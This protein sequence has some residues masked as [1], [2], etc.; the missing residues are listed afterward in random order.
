MGSNVFIIA[1]RTRGEF[2]PLESMR[3]I[4]ENVRERIARFM[5]EKWNRTLP[6]DEMMADR[7]KKARILGLGEGT[8]VYENSYIYGKPK[9]GKDVWIG[10]LT[11]LDAT[12]GLQIGNNCSIAAGVHIYTHAVQDWVASEG[13]IPKSKSP[14]KIEDYV[15]VG[16]NAVVLPGV[17]IGH[18]SIIGAGSVVTQSIPPSSVAVGIPAAVIKTIES[19]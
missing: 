11:L 6:L 14:V 2:M 1:R 10:P 17:T 19:Q 13:K 5:M 3:A 4:Y 9:I 7:W 15:A 16:A 8:S 18:H 12:G